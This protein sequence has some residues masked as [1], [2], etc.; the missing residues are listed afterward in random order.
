MK[1]YSYQFFFVV[2]MNFFSATIIG[3]QWQRK[4][5]ERS[6]IVKDSVQQK[7][8]WQQPTAYRLEPIPSTSIQWG[9]MCRKEWALEKKTGIPLKFRLGSVEEVNKLEG[10]YIH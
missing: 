5:F 3:Q 6:I 2:I 9:I 10:K 1:N 4:P 8:I 7:T